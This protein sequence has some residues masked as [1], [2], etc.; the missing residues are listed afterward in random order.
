MELIKRNIHMDRVRAEAVTQFTVEDDVN[1]PD[2]KPDVNSL[3]LE[4]GELIIEEIKPGNDSV[5]V[6][7]YLACVVLYHTSEEGSSLVV[8]DARLPFDEKMNLRGAVPADSVSVDGEV[9]DL[10]VSMINS[11]KLN[12]QSLVTLTA[13]V[14][15]LYD[16]EAPTAVHGEEKAEYRRMPLEIAQIVICKNDIFRI[17]DEITLPSNYPNIFQILWDTVSLGDVE[18]KVMEE[19][20]TLSGDVHVFLLYEGEGENHPVRSFETTLPFSGVLECHG[21]REG[22]LPDIRY[23]LGQKELAVRPDFD[24]E[25]RS[26]GIEMVLDFVIRIYEEEKLEII[27]DVYGV[28]NEI[29]TVTHRADLRRL[30]ARVTGK[31]KV[32]DHVHIKVGNVLQLLHSEGTVALEQQTAVENGILLQGSLTVKLMYITGADEAPYGCTQAQIPYQYTLEVPD[33]SPEDTDTVHAEVEQ[34]Q[35]TML[36]GEEMDVKAVLCFSTVVFKT[37]PVE[38][39]SQISVAP[40]DTG[41]MSSLPGMVVYMVKEGDNLWNIGKKYYAPVDSLRRL[42]ELE[43]DELKA[44]QKLLIVK[45]S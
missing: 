11:R 22:M 27:S 32:T 19:K 29:T 13:R 31:T 20:I 37:V 35:V 25:E 36:D 12:I 39:I 2:S 41:K 10:T 43:S 40:L 18:F 38:L 5:S 34:L 21:C 14:E 42:N 28:S 6:R 17:K 3:N 45:G 7:G 24:G 8:T 30:L 26:I 15:E 33:I 44:G 23:K 1:I 9:E 4:K 16:E